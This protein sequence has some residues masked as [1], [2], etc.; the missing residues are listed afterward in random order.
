MNTPISSPVITSTSKETSTSESTMET[1]SYPTPI[2][3]TPDAW[4]RAPGLFKLPTI[5][6]KVLLERSLAYRKKEMNVENVQNSFR[7]LAF[8]GDSLIYSEFVLILQEIFPHIQLK[9][10]SMLRAKLATR[11]QLAQFSVKCGLSKMVKS[12]PT[13]TQIDVQGECMEAYIGA[14]FLDRGPDGPAEVRKLLRTFV[15][16]FIDE[17]EEKLKRGQ[18]IAV[19]ESSK[20]RKSKKKTPISVGDK[21]NNHKSGDMWDIYPAR[22]SSTGKSRA[23]GGFVS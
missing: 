4:I 6:N 11:E 16:W 9:H 1:K 20:T 8:L 15:R 19:R 18:E 14:L 2:P 5:H 10:I 17:N 3:S 7:Q 13:S 12:N 23:V 21:N 22:K